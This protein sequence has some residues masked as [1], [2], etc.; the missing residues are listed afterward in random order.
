MNKE[1]SPEYKLIPEHMLASIEG[2]VKY[3]HQLGGFLTAV[4]S[5]DLFKAIAR[6]DDQNVTLLRTYVRYINWECPGGCHGSLETVNRW[7]QEKRT[8]N[9]DNV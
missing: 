5:N 6:G 3:G 4:F 2:Y 1:L 8:E 9:I 7:I